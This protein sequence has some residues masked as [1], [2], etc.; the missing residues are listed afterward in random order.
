M[1]GDGTMLGASGVEVATEEVYEEVE[2]EE[3][4]EEELSWSSDSEIGDTLDYLDA[5]DDSEVINGAFVPQ[6]RRPNAHG[7]LHSRPNA[8]SLQPLSNRSMK[9]SDRIRASPLEVLKLFVRRKEYGQELEHFVIVCLMR[10]RVSASYFRNI[11]MLLLI[12]DFKFL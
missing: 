3:D 7:G 2:G 10:I 5:W 6:T 11:F 1:N 8:S 4:E 9:V 12:S